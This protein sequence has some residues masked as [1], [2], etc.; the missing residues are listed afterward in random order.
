MRRPGA[1]CGVHP[2]ISGWWRNQTAQVKAELLWEALNRWGRGRCWILRRYRAAQRDH[3]RCRCCSTTQPLPNAVL[4]LG[5]PGLL[6]LG[7]PRSIPG[8]GRRP[9]SRLSTAL[10]QRHLWTALYPG[11][12]ML[13]VGT[14]AFRFLAS[15]LEG[16]GERGDGGAKGG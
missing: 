6:G 7:A 5:G 13:C 16:L 9:C 4:V 14:R 10:P 8:M 12:A 1:V 3:T 15:G 2:P 11:L